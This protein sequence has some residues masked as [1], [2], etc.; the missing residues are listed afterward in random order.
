[1]R[2]HQKVYGTI[3]ERLRARCVVDIRTGCWEWAGSRCRK[4]YGMIR[5]TG[6]TLRVHRVAHEE[7]LGPI[8]A[9]LDV[10]HRCDNPPCFNPG[11]LWTGT[12]LD[13]A[14]DRAAKR[15]GNRD[16]SAATAASALAA[17]S[18]T[19]CVSGHPFNERNTWISARGT[20]QCRECD[21]LR[22]LQQR[23]AK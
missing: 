10:L 16:T 5:V 14:R 23:A 9:G 20:R 1:M 17:R 7:W 2:R 19:E 3:S 13:N 11:H 21:R 18:K 22:H 4:G 6:R 15:R 12:D 8:P